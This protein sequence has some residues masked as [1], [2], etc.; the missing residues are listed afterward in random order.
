MR[1]SI[2]PTRQAG[3]YSAAAAAAATAACRFRMAVYVDL[4]EHPTAATHTH[5]KYGLPFQKV[6]T[7]S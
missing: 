2:I 3:R 5:L 4:A 7:L 1:V 6:K